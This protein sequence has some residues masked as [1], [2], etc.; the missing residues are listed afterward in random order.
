VSPETRAGFECGAL[1]DGV[2]GRGMHS[3]VEDVNCVVPGRPQSRRHS[4]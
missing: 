2:V 4:G 3:V 1:E